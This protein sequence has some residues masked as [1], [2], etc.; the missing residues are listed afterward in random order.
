[1]SKQRAGDT[2]RQAYA[3]FWKEWIILGL[4]MALVAVPVP[5]IV[6]VQS[7]VGQDV[8]EGLPIEMIVQGVGGLAMAYALIFKIAYDL[9]ANRYML[10]DEEV[11]EIYGIIQKNRVATKLE[12][13]R[14]VSVEIG[15]VG[16]IFGF[17]DVLYYTA[18]SGGVDVRL[19][20]IPNP[21][22]L[23]EEADMLAKRKQEEIKKKQEEEDD[24]KAYRGQASGAV[25]SQILDAFKHSVTESI[26]VQRQILKAIGELSV[27]TRK[28]AA[29]LQAATK[30]SGTR[31]RPVPGRSTEHEN[32][33]KPDSS[34]P[35]NHLKE[36]TV[37]ASADDSIESE[38]DI[39]EPSPKMFD[40]DWEDILAPVKEPGKSKG[41][42]KTQQVPAH[43]S[44]VTDEKEPLRREPV[45]DSTPGEYVG[46]MTPRKK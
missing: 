22:Q 40:G 1:M 27:E 3:A 26:T 7:R 37:Y 17:G 20:D 24:K 14:R 41:E 32:T 42:P 9:L 30:E 35:D 34:E 16:R 25:D 10:T 21:T 2:I 36:H 19:K 5:L 28:N 33:E 29:I 39:P 13:I 38:E 12:H 4:G 46:L 11:V 6:W 45:D 8:F 18:G 43:V 15:I 23:A 44:K 31:E